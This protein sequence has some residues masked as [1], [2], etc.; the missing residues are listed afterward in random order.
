MVLTVI[1]VEYK[2]PQKTVQYIKKL[3]EVLVTD[4]CIHFVIVD[5]SV[6]TKN[7][8]RI[9]DELYKIGFP[10]NASETNSDFYISHEYG[11][12]Q[13]LV[14]QNKTNSGYAKGNNLGVRSAM[15][16]WGTLGT[17]L[18]SNND[19]GIYTPIDLNKI[20]S[21]YKN[22]SDVAVIGPKIIGLDGK[23]QNPYEKKT[24]WQRWMK[25]DLLWPL[26]KIFRFIKYDDVDLVEMNQNGYVYRVMGSFLFIDGKSF[27]EIQGFD[28]NTFL[29]GEEMI[30]SERFAKIG[31][32]NYYLNE[33][34]VIHEHGKTIAK[35]HSRL[36]KLRIRFE[37]EMYY[38]EK[39]RGCS[40]FSIQLARLFFEFYI[41]KSKL[42]EFCYGKEKL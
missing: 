39:Y 36:E 41:L 13:I 17:I 22:N 42:K 16:V 34:I 10:C 15:N 12:K 4:E 27:V 23:A 33:M 31:K 19:I 28:E 8:D 29:Y 14:I 20:E 37:S 30:L 25:Y 11:N 32:R 26:D 35:F 38:Y 1:V 18:I 3:S 40:K 24:L 7:T 21:I 6:S 9:L 5:N 2:T